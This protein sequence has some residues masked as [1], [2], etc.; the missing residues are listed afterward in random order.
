[1]LT[2]VV[3][4]PVVVVLVL[5]D[6]DDDDEAVGSSRGVTP[7]VMV[8]GSPAAEVGWKVPAP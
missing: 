3:E 7:G 6:D 4:V 5:D 1:V 2:P 8:C